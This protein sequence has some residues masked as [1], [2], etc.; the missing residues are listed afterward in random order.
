MTCVDKLKELHPDWGQDEIDYALNEECPDAY[1]DIDAP[2]DEFGILWC[3]TDRCD[4][5]WNREIPGTEPLT[6]EHTSEPIG[7][8]TEIIEDENGVTAKIEPT[9]SHY[10][11]NEK[12]KNMATRKTKAELM[13]ELENIKNTK[14]ELEKELQNL[15]KYKQYEDMAG[16]IHALYMAYVHAGFSEE[17]AYDLLKTMIQNAGKITFNTAITPTYKNRR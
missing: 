13:E 8:V 17:Q 6:Y 12:E 10:V 4:E 5:C 15:E 3:G 9:N 2:K 16:E 14:E 1:I 11:R 7:K